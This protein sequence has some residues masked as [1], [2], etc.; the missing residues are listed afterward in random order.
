LVGPVAKDGSGVWQDDPYNRQ[1][2]PWLDETGT[3]FYTHLQSSTAQAELYDYYATLTAARNDHVALRL[4][5]YRTLLVDNENALYAYGRHVPEYG[6]AIV[7]I[8]RDTSPQ[9]VSLDVD[10]YMPYQTNLAD[11][12]SSNTYTISTSGMVENIVVPGNSGAV[13]V[14]TGSISSPPEPVIDLAVT[15]TGADTVALAWSVAVSA[16]AYEVYRSYLS[17]G[18]Y[19]LV[20]ETNESTFTYTDTGLTPGQRVYYIVIAKSTIVGLLSGP[21]NEVTA[22]PA[23]TIDWANLQWPYVINH[24]IGIVPTENIYGQVWI[25]GVTLEPGAT[26]GLWAQVGF[27]PDGSDPDA[28]P[29]WRWVEAV[30]NAQSGENDEFMGQLLPEAVGTFDFCYRYSTNLGESWYYADQNGGEYSTEI[31][32]H[33][34]VSPSED[35]AAPSA[36]VLSIA[37]WSASS[38]SLS[39]TE[40]IDDVEVYA[41]DIYRSTDNITFSKIDR[42][43]APT[44]TYTDTTVVTDQLYYYYVIALDTSFNPSMPSN[45]VSQIAEA[46][47]VAVTFEVTVPEWTPGVVYLVGSHPAV[48]DWNPSAVAMTKV[49]DTLWTHTAD[50]LDGTTFDFKITRGNWETVMKGAD[51]NEELTNLPITVDYGTDG[52]QTYAYTVLN[53]RDPIVISTSPVNSAT[54]VPVDASIVVTWSQAMAASA[55]PDVWVEPDPSDLIPATCSF[56]TLTNEMTITPTDSLPSSALIGVGLTGLSDAGGDTQQVS[57]PLFFTTEFVDPLPFKTYLPLILR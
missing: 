5:D 18:G 31:T 2:Y 37:D 44:L 11:V 9:Q 55:C 16:N 29:E 40:S 27:G 56:D 28:N 23:Y 53:W 7:V 46:K 57:Y 54:D 13:L 33:M 41:Y 42:V 1:P 52:T 3:P 39:W 12:L 22:L 36:P 20:G 43:L 51:G 10:G 17:G 24:T 8:N 19:E 50:I 6:V 34:V 38:I 45:V 21:S 14:S 15:Y 48:G 49:S 35:T 26:P 30:F 25:A 47:L 4:G 32:G